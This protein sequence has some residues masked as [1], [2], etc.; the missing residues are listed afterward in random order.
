MLCLCVSVTT[1][2]EAASSG[3]QSW[4]LASL[5]LRK[6]LES[7][8][9]H[10]LSRFFMNLHKFED[11]GNCSWDAS[12]D[13]DRELLE[14]N[15]YLIAANLKDNEA[16]LPHLIVQLWH[17]VSLLPRGSVFVSIYEDQSSDGTGETT[18][19]ADQFYFKAF[20]A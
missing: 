16:V 18:T 2:F 15:K 13:I 5:N 14:G 20:E 17:T 9:Y 1:P 6:E 3:L 12:L 19:L 7:S 8:T 4:E 10:T 11:A